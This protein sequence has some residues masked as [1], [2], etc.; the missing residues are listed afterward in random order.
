VWKNESHHEQDI[1]QKEAAWRI[2]PALSLH[3]LLYSEFLDKVPPFIVAI[4]AQRR[5]MLTNNP[6]Q[7]TE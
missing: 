7:L 5:M 4:V 6:T 2:Q 1:T 3:P